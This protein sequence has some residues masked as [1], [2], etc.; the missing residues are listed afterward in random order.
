MA[1]E[2]RYRKFVIEYFN[3]GGNQTQAAIN[4]GYSP[5]SAYMQGSRLMK[6]AKV[7]K[8]MEEYKADIYGNLR[9]RM[10][11]GAVKAYDAILSIATNPQADDRDRLAAMMGHTAQSREI[12]KHYKNATVSKAD[13]EK[14]WATVPDSE[15]AVVE[16]ETRKARKGA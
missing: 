2:D 6:N 8:I 9:T 14:Y 5:R 13:A 3:C 1:A 12:E 16:T 11:A 10:A 15:K 4:A 7:K